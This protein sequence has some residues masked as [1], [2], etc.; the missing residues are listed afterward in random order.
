VITRDTKDWTWVL[1]RPCPECG[2]D[3]RAISPQ[4]VPALLRENAAAW[5]TILTGD[6]D[7]RQRSKPDV[8]SPLEYAC[9]VRDVCRIYDERLT[10]MLTVDAPEYP[11]WD[12]DRT[13]VEDRYSEQ[14]PR[15]VATELTAAVETLAAHFA[16]VSG[17]DW[18][19]TGTR[20]DGAHFTIAT[21]ARYFI[22][23]PIHHLHD[24]T[25]RIS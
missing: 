14:D 22:H 5:H 3:T 25:G 8:W 24:A 19:R 23:D 16:T 21:F 6:R 7:P 13:A 18:E 9:H 10:L 4:Q 17:T 2:F 20:G 1:H 15:T 11:N 12:Q